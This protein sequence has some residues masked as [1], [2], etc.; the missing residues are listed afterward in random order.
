MRE[1]MRQLVSNEVADLR[2]EVLNCD[3]GGDDD[4]GDGDGGGE[5]NDERSRLQ[6]AQLS[7][8]IQALLLR[9]G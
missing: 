2:D 6:K 8:T 3:D 5:N 1:E 9:I 7:I 4:D